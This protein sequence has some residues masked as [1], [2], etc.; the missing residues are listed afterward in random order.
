MLAAPAAPA[1]PEPVAGDLTP[2]DAAPAP[3]ATPEPSTATRE[4]LDPSKDTR[5]G[6]K[7]TAHD[8]ENSDTANSV[9]DAAGPSGAATPLW[10][11]I[12]GTVIV[13]AAATLSF[14]L[15]WRRDERARQTA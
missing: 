1:A 11:A 3:A 8:D 5:V 9:T 10:S 14:R 7:P 13:A 4:N 2:L 6:V 12:L 15:R